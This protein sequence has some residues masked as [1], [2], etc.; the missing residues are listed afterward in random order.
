[1]INLVPDLVPK[2]G[3]NY[4]TDTDRFKCQILNNEHWHKS[5]KT[6]MSCP[7]FIAE[8]TMALLDSVPVT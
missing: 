3:K 8:L 2:T 4:E 6:F 1:M 7:S 5:Y